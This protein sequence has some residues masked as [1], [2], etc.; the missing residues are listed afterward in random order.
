MLLALSWEFLKLTISFLILLLSIG[1]PLI[2]EYSTYSLLCATT[3]STRLLLHVYLS[4]TI[5]LYVHRSEVAY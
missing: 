3:A 1:C 4:G 5:L 2:H